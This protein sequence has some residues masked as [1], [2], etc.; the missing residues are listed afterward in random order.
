MFDGC[1]PSVFQNK[2]A[3]DGCS[4]FPARLI[5]RYTLTVIHD[6]LCVNVPLYACSQFWKA[7][8][9]A[10]MFAFDLANQYLDFPNRNCYGIPRHDSHVSGAVAS[11]AWKGY[12]NS[13]FLTFFVLSQSALSNAPIRKQVPQYL[14]ACSPLLKP[15]HSR[16]MSSRALP[17]FKPPSQSACSFVSRQNL[18]IYIRILLWN[19]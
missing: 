15:N 8:F 6:W 4:L 2:I 12:V 10:W 18:D 5:F 19:M 14:Y 16:A 13:L 3:K 11:A 1:S 9:G 7:N 17:G